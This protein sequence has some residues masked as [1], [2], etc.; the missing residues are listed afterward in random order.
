MPEAKDTYKEICVDCKHQKTNMKN[1][2]RPRW[3]MRVPLKDEEREKEKNV[4]SSSQVNLKKR[5][6]GKAAY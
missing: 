5:E 1:M 4:G 6:V 2:I 3:M